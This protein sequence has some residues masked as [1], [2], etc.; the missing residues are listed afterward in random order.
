[1]SCIF[2]DIA[3]GKAPC[4]KIWEDDDHLAFLSIFPNTD[5]FSVVIPKAHHPSYAFDLPDEVLSAL[6]LATKRVAKQLDRA[7]DDVG[8][9]GMVFEGYGVD[10]VHAKLIPLHGTASL[11]QWRPIESTSP[12]FFARYEGYISSHDAA[13]ADDEQL[14]ALA[15]RIRQRAV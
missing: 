3:A 7:F 8:R 9:C 12:K 6:M 1:M 10:H 5:G 15:A 14:A 4:H 11:D 13:R 2:C